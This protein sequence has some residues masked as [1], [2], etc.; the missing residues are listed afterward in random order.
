LGRIM[1]DGHD[2]LRNLFQVSC[3]ELDAIVDHVRLLVDTALGDGEVFGA[4]MTGAG[5]GGCAL[6]LARPERAP[7]L[8]SELTEM[9]R[10]RFGRDPGI[11]RVSA[12]DGARLLPVTRGSGGDASPSPGA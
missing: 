12:A 3:P 5:F 10:T 9:F 2:S 1:L 6:V 8:S 11:A 4:R 7:T